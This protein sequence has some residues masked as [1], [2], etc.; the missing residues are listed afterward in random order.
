MKT[1]TI[2]HLRNLILV[3][4]LGMSGCSIDPS[5]YSE[6][7]PETFYDSQTSVW[8]RFN[9]PFTHWRWYVASDA[10]RWNMQELGT[11]EMCLPTRGS[12]WYNGGVYQQYHYHQFT[13]Q[14][15]D[16]YN[17]W[18]GFSMGVA[19]AW[20]TMEDIEEHVDFDAL[21][22][23]P[24]IRESMKAQQQTLVAYFYKDGLDFFGGVPLY[25]TTQ[26][27]VKGRSTAAETFQFIDSLLDAAIPNL[28]IKSTLGGME[29]GSISQAA[30]AALKAQLYFNA[31]AY[32]GEDKFTECA[33]IC[34]D[35]ISGKYGTYALAND[36][37]NIFGFKN[38]TCPEIIWTVPSE[39][40]KLET[41]GGYYSTMH[42]YNLKNYL[43]G[44]DAGANNG[45]CL[46]PSLKPSG[47]VYTEF[48]LGK[49]YAKFESADVRKQPYV[50][51]GTE[52][53]KGMF[54]VGKL[55][56]PLDGGT[57]L[58]NREYNGEIITMVDQVAPFKKLGKDYQDVA[59]LPSK[60][61]T[62]E[63][64]SG[65]RLMKRSPMP[66]YADRLLRYNPDVPI[67]RLTEIYY[68]LAECKMRA[69]DLTEAANL[70][71]QVRKRYFANGVDPNPVT[72]ANLDKYRML[73]EWMI[74]F[75]GEGRRRTDLIR[76]NAYTTENWWD[77]S[78]T[79]DPNKNHF[80]VHET[81]LSS[82]NLIKQNDG[83]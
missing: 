59:S 29:T 43:G 36:W 65:V 54:I 1:K 22:F 51:T 75:L 23:E 80:P 20:D 44:I 72:A 18:Y 64:N 3:T 39:N 25:T 11:D 14:L 21:G 30:G 50:Y 60:I 34:Q 66:T 42:H 61:S 58:G 49:P 19:L 57:C 52:Q 53:Y 17:G 12:D 26:S 74:E 15:G 46:T 63:E 83:Y 62:A 27:E 69:G 56:N 8:Q 6:V 2:I 79:N 16:L 10:A 5:Y 38:E 82:N 9:R 28:P 45:Y 48:K 35:I 78:A 7:V 40:S 76:W 32:I 13:P 33:Q 70:I 73:D 77:H 37:T 67:I 41:D 47:S 68:M 55:V 71:N 24:G 4:I 31:N 81:I